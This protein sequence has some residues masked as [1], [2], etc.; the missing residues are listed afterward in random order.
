MIVFI[1]DDYV[2]ENRAVVTVFDRGFLYGDGLFET[3]F[4][5]NGIPFRFGQ[6]LDRLRSGAQFLQIG[7]NDSDAVMNARVEELLKRN[8]ITECAL[9]IQLTRGIGARGYSPKNADDPTLVLSLHP[10]PNDT[11][12][13]HAQWKVITS[14]FTVYAGDPLTQYKTTNKLSNVCARAEADRNGANDALLLNHR[15]EVAESSSANVFWIAR[16]TVWTPP[17]ESGALPGITRAV[18]LEI[19]SALEFHWEE[20]SISLDALKKAEAVFLTTSTRGLV[21]VT[22]IDGNSVAVSPIVDQLRAA[23]RIVQFKELGLR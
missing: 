5:A 6:H 15:R 3:V 12:P 2:P 1:N 22:K 11:A 14:S 7:W 4:V 8:G 20:C 16:D 21:E 9:R 18:V 13:D 17:I 19:C 10:P 23:Y